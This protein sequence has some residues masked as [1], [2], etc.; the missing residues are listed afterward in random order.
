ML[1]L[2]EKW[3]EVQNYSAENVPRRVSVH[4]QQTTPVALKCAR[5]QDFKITMCWMEKW[6]LIDAIRWENPIVHVMLHITVEWE[7]NDD[8]YY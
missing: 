7:H 5:F 3:V 8:N 4:F 2:T 1:L 6:K